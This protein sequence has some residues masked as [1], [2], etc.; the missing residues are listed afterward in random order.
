MV[1]RVGSQRGFI[2]APRGIEAASLA[3]NDA[4]FVMD[5]RMLR[6]EFQCLQQ[7]LLSVFEVAF[8]MQGNAE[9]D[10]RSANSRCTL[11]N[12]F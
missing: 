12:C 11:D 9:I 7:A 6:I 10:L 1:S 3:I 2:T 4:E 5:Y 8:T